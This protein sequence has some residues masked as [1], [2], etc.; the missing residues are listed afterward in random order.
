M[1]SEE[2]DY[3]SPRTRY[4][5][6]FVAALGYK[7]RKVVHNNFMD[8]RFSLTQENGFTHYV[9]RK[10]FLAFAMENHR[11]IRERSEIMLRNI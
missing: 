8:D 1:R 9:K 2:I 4:S 3:I 10:D 11:N 5:T 7:V 6:S